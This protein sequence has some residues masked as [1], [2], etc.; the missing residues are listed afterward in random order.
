[1]SDSDSDKLVQF[2]GKFSEPMSREQ[3]NRNDPG[4]IYITGTGRTLHFRAQVI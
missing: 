1:M 4:P 3:A 2:M